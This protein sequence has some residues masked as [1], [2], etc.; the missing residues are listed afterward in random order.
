[1]SAEM[2]QDVNY[3]LKQDTSNPENAVRSVRGESK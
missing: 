2:S 3:K 1:M